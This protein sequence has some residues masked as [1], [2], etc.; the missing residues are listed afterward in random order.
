M[1][2]KTEMVIFE[3]ILI[4]LNNVSIKGDGARNIVLAQDYIINKAREL[5]K[6]EPVEEIEE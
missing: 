6:E 1:D 5:A 2:K 3:T 4:A